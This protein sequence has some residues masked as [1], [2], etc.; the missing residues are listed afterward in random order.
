[1]A[2]W[3]IDALIWIITIA[4]YSLAPLHDIRDQQALLHHVAL[5]LMTIYQLRHLAMFGPT[6]RLWRPCLPL[7]FNLAGLAGEV[8]DKNFRWILITRCCNKRLGSRLLGT[9][10]VCVKTESIEAGTSQPSYQT[11]NNA[12]INYSAVCMPISLQSCSQTWLRRPS[13]LESGLAHA[14]AAK[15]PLSLVFL[16]RSVGVLA[17]ELPHQTQ[18]ANPT[19]AWPA[20][21]YSALTCF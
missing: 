6:G 21:D 11:Q 12:Q 14:L 4:S 9:P 20:K 2:A 8:P 17:D 19:S 13:Q 5:S 7:L 15:A 10:V 16:E 3:V 1:M 18:R